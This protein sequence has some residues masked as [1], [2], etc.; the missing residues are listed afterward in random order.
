[1][2]I[3][4]SLRPGDRVRVKYI[5]LVRDAVVVS[6]DLVYKKVEMDVMMIT[7]RDPKPRVKRLKLPMVNLK[8]IWVVDE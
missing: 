2:K 5:K 4:H 7:Y 8:E 6:V 1:M 3:R